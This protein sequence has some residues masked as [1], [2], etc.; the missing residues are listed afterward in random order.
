M[1]AKLIAAITRLVI[2]VKWKSIKKKYQ[3]G[4]SPTLDAEGHW[5]LSRASC[6]R[7]MALFASNQQ[8][9]AMAPNLNQLSIPQMA[10]VTQYIGW[11]SMVNARLGRPVAVEGDLTQST[12]PTLYAIELQLVRHVLENNAFPAAINTKAINDAARLSSYQHYRP[13]LNRTINCV[14]LVSGTITYA[15]T[16]LGFV[17]LMWPFITAM[18]ASLPVALTISAVML[19]GVMS[20]AMS[21]ASRYVISSIADDIVSKAVS[22]TWDQVFALT[23]PADALLCGLLS[24]LTINNMIEYENKWPIPDFLAMTPTEAIQFLYKADRAIYA[25][26][27]QVVVPDEVGP[28]IAAQRKMLLQRYADR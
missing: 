12:L 3:S 21:D 26:Y 5:A 10:N 17:L 27:L 20:Y 4:T 15:S 1:R 24:E 18:H 9:S 11:L 23:S 8:N 13:L 28:A 19:L 2:K 14:H 25:K 16:V 7:F 6:Q 22:S